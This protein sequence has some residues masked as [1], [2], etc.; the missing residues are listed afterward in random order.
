M[1]KGAAPGSSSLGPGGIAMD[2]R[3]GAARSEDPDAAHCAA[4]SEDPGAAHAHRPER[5]R[6]AVSAYW[7]GMV[8]SFGTMWIQV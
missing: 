4:R 6:N 7:L 1:D 8:Q 3:L 5:T 2:R